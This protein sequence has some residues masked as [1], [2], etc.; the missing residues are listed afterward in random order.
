MFGDAEQNQLGK[1]LM[2]TAFKE[3]L[4]CLKRYSMGQGGTRSPQLHTAVQ[5]LWVKK[6]NR[7]QK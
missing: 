7:K 4:R 1:H 6:T 2:I 5:I 3:Q